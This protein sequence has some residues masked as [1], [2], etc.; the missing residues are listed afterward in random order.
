MIDT[1]PG[2]NEEALV[3]I[4]LSDTLVLILRPDN[5]DFQDAAV[6]VELARKLDVADVRVLINKVPDGVDW[7]FL[8]SQVEARYGAPVVGMM[9]LCSEM[10]QLASGALFVV[11]HPDH[12]LSSQLAEI[13]ARIFP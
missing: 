4:V 9:P 10:A 6:V 1:H 8:R 2:V 12:H 13:A 7:D 5:Q 3:S 11:R